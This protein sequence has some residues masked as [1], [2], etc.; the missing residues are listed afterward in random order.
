MNSFKRHLGL[1]SSD[2]PLA[3]PAY[4]SETLGGNQADMRKKMVSFW[5]S[6]KY[7]K[8]LFQLT[9]EAGQSEFNGSAPVWLQGIK[10]HR[11]HLSSLGCH[12]EIEQ[13]QVEKARKRCTEA[14]YSDFHSRIWITYRREF[15][16]FPGSSMTSDC[17]WGCM[18]RSGQMVLANTLLLKHLGRHWRWR[19]HRGSEA[20]GGMEAEKEAM[21]KALVRLFGDTSE[22]PISIQNLMGLAKR[23]FDKQPGDWFGPATTAHLLQEALHASSH[24]LLAD[25]CIYERE[26]PQ[27]LRPSSDVVEAKDFQ[28][29]SDETEN[30][31]LD[32]DISIDGSHW[33]MEGPVQA[34][35]P[36]EEVAPRRPTPPP[37]ESPSPDWSPVLLLV[38][39]RIG[40]DRVNPVYVPSLMKY[41]TSEN[42]LGIIGGRPKH[43]LYFVGLQGDYLI[44][45]D[46]HLVQDSVNVFHRSFNPESYH[47][48]SPRKMHIQKMDPSCSFA[49][50]CETRED[51]EELCLTAQSSVS[52]RAQYPMFGINDGSAKDLQTNHMSLLETEMNL[53]EDRLSE[54]GSNEITEDFVPLGNLGVVL[55]HTLFRIH[56]IHTP[57]MLLLVGVF[58]GSSQYFGRPISCQ[59]TS[60]QREFMETHCWARGVFTIRPQDGA[61]DLSEVAQAGISEFDPRIHEKIF[62][63]HYH[64]TPLVFGL[65][66][67]L[68]ALPGWAWHSKRVQWLLRMCHDFSEAH[69]NDLELEDRLDML[70]TRYLRLG[71]I[72]RRLS[73]KYFTCEVWTC[74]NVVFHLGWST[75]YMWDGLHAFRFDSLQLIPGMGS[76]NMAAWDLLFPKFGICDYKNYGISG[77]IQTFYSL[78]HLPLNYGTEKCFQICFVWFLLLTSLSLVSLGYRF[79]VMAFHGARLAA[80]MGIQGT[81]DEKNYY[82]VCHRANYGHWYFLTVLRDNID[83]L[84]FHEFIIRLATIHRSRM[85]SE[86]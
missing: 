71:H 19:G 27:V 73:V 8:A 79:M 42:C 63:R 69:K 10:Y 16:P 81:L 65:S 33:V 44:N 14:F 34:P 77:E 35:T 45:L 66:S 47:C 53:D 49:F 28:L 41:L 26:Q 68:F 32:Q 52:S 40:T 80:M 84:T 30:F 82:I 37:E 24:P 23:R 9:N 38:P 21:H 55:E 25:L 22:A 15:E 74:L 59:V 57:G 11:G 13:R 78:C 54:N 7:G 83:A 67:L 60:V 56:T 76:S 29:L 50:Y 4:A 72:F 2:T 61:L 20:Q 3:E 64:T 58:M 62:H 17:G 46:P 51:F 5:H 70:V 36:A 12:D 75:W 85:S 39:V 86:G 43:A 1:G 31:A 48:K 18:L 6:M